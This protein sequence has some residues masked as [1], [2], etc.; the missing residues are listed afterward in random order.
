MRARRQLGF[1]ILE[2]KA[3]KHF[4]GA[5]LKNSHAKTKRP[6][7]TKRSMHLVMRS[8][9]AKGAHSFLRH[10]KGVRS[11]I[12]KQAKLSGVKLYRTAIAGNHFHLIILPSSRQ[13]FNRFVRAIS[14][15]IARTVLGAQ[16]GSAMGIHFWEKRPFTR[17]VEWGQDF[18]KACA[19][20]TQNSLEA[21]G[22][23][24]YKHR[25]SRYP[26]GGSTG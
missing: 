1:E 10:D 18:Q 14:G 17:I 19:Y 13:A 11:I 3:A 25:N 8:F 21:L 22:F 15:L 20:L 16:R 5:H 2:A 23:I 7:T 12:Q 9:Y 24:P 6:I 26:A 4:G